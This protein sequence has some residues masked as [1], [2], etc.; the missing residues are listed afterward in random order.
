VLLFDY[1]ITE[2]EM[3]KHILVRLGCNVTLVDIEEDC[4][5]KIHNR[6]YHLVIFDHSIPALDITDFV[7]HIERIDLL[8]PIAM[9]V[10]LSI[11][12]YEK[13]YSCSGIDFLIFKPF[14]LAEMVELIDATKALYQ[15]RRSSQY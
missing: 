13:K 8:L 10:T 11:A 1:Q 3:I 5:E 7:S 6:P 4:Y 2:M 15:R 9:M 12:F 14:G